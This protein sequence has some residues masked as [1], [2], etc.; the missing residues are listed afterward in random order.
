MYIEEESARYYDEYKEELHGDKK[1]NSFLKLSTVGIVMLPLSLVALYYFSSLN[2]NNTLIEEESKL[3]ISIQSQYLADGEVKDVKEEE[4]SYFSSNQ[5]VNQEAIDT[6]TKMILSKL[7]A[8]KNSLNEGSVGSD[9]SGK[10]SFEQEL[11]IAENQKS[12]LTDIK[13]VNYYNKV[14][15]VQ[16]DES[17]SEAEMVQKSLDNVIDDSV[18]DDDTVFYTNSLQEEITVRSNEMKIII[19]QEGDTLSR[20][21]EKAYGD[22]FAYQKIFMANPELIENP[23][24][25]FIGQ[26]LRIPS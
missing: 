16:E 7:E 22:A 2:S 18:V 15:V 24:K 3:P 12:E 8:D 11:L 13:E 25:I 6:I 1:S 21:A 5:E 26:K 4:T 23:D 19:V 17:S 10:I 14:I 20:I 9:S